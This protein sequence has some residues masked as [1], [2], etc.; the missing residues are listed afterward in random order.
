MTF[1]QFG[2][3]LTEL[4]PKRYSSK[5]KDEAIAAMVKLVENKAPGTNAAT[6][7]FLYNTIFLNENFI[8]KTANKSNVDRMTDTS[9][10]TGA[11]KSRFD[12]DGKG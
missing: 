4:A 1:A 2:Q 9:K 5:T 6:V 10:Y 8:Q 12:A 11:H 7:I 3:A